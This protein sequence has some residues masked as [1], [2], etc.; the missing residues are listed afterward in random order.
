MKEKDKKEISR[1]LS[2]W[3]RHKPGDLILDKNG[4]CSTESILLKTSISMEELEDIVETN[5]KKRFSF[6]DDK[7]KIRANQGHSIKVDVQLEKKI[8]PVTLYHGTSPKNYESIKKKG[9]EKRNRNHVHLSDNKFTATSVG[10]RHCKNNEKP[11]IIEIDT[12]QMVKDGVDFF[13]SA[14]GVW[15]TDKVDKKYL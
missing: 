15:L 9:L 14:N 8:P 4:W 11:K 2:Y 10:S 1:S 12:R 6:N 5:N 7:T 3:L 13:L